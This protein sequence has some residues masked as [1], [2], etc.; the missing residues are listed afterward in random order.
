MH[1]IRRRSSW[2][3]SAT[4]GIGLL[5][6]GVSLGGCARVKSRPSDPAVAKA[7][8][9]IAAKRGRDYLIHLDPGKAIREFDQAQNLDPDLTF[10]YLGR[11][12]A[13]GRKHRW[14]KALEDLQR[15]IDLEPNS[16]V[17]RYLRGWVHAE[18]GEHEEAIADFSDAIERDRTF[19]Q[20]HSARANEY[21]ALHDENRVRADVL[22]AKELYRKLDRDDSRPRARVNALPVQ[23]P[24]MILDKMYPL[25]TPPAGAA[26]P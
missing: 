23:W 14:G 24:E 13:Y 2:L 19:W 10:A 18:R 25:A 26:S 8:A 3:S 15:A 11:G 21:R 17:A 1:A 7:E 22:L 16:A 12:L 5:S 6:L 9:Y 4:V 20:A